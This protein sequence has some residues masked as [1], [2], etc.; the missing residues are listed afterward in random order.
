M[1]ESGHNHKNMPMEIRGDVL[2]NIENGAYDTGRDL[3]SPENK[4]ELQKI[5]RK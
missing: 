3:L 4:K 5:A 1:D 2:A